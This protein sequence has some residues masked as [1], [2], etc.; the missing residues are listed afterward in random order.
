MGSQRLS[1][2]LEQFDRGPIPTDRL[3]ELRSL[4]VLEGIG[5]DEARRLLEKV[6]KEAPSPRLVREAKAALE[7]LNR[8]AA[9]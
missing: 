8:R 3:R 1:R 5:T 7:R 4:E 2:L 6:A 9:P